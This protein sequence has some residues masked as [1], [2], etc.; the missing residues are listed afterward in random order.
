MVMAQE[1]FVGTW[2]LIAS[3]FR[4]ADGTVIYPYGQDAIGTLYYDAAGN[5]AVQ[6]LRVDRPRFADGD[7][8]RGTPDEIK[9]AFE[10]SL[11][12]FGRYEVDEE[13]QLVIHHV[14]GCSF[15]NWI[16]QPQKRFFAFAENQLTLS[17]PPLQVG[18][19]TITGILRWQRSG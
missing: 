18:G 6:L 5:M 16:G 14:T 3:E 12:Y 19:T 10:G 17:T 15:P 9:A 7:R 13:A 8:Q 4:R 2:Q 11:A 1:Q